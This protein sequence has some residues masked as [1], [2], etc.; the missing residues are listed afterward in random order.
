[1]LSVILQTCDEPNVLDLTIDNINKELASVPDSELILSKNYLCH[2]PDSEY[3][4]YIEADCL[5][6]SGYFGSMMGLF[7]KNPYY[8]K[9]AMLSPSVGVKYWHDRVFGYNID[10]EWSKIVDNQQTNNIH[11]YPIKA[12]KSTSTYAIQVGYMPGSIIRT[13]ALK[14]VLKKNQCKGDELEMSARLSL[15]FWDTGRRVHVNPNST[16]VTNLEYVGQKSKF[17]PIV[18]DKVHKIFEKEEL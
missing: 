16:Y 6:N 17:A 7:K 15:A 1:M 14:D 8:R 10:R 18:T 12:K 13:S 11:L 9:L 5:V 3:V 2:V 4:C